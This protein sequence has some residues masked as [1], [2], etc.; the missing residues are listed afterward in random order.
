LSSTGQ[1]LPARLATA[2]SRPASPRPAGLPRSRIS[3]SP[4]PR[5]SA[6]GTT[7]SSDHPRQ[8]WRRAPPTIPPTA[9]T[10][11]SLLLRSRGRCP[12]R[13]AC[14][15]QRRH[16]RC[17]GPRLRPVS[18][19][20]PLALPLRL[21]LAGGLAH[22]WFGCCWSRRRGRCEAPRARISTWPTGQ[23][24]NFTAAPLRRHP[25]RSAPV[26]LQVSATNLHSAS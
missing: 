24:R 21:T 26:A 2:D 19:I 3:G 1:V 14:R 9:P 13:R 18:Q 8:T 5:I 12:R 20:R 23:M 6:S 17:Q 4:F 25:L 7:S 22:R 11:S 10:S 15:R 16:G